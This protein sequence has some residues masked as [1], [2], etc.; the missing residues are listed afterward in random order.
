MQPA[1]RLEV[2]G[3]RVAHLLHSF[4]IQTLII[5]KVLALKLKFNIMVLVF[6]PWWPGL[7]LGLWLLYYCCQLFNNS[8][9]DRSRAPGIG[10]ASTEALL[11]RTYIRKL[12]SKFEFRFW[13]SFRQKLGPGP[14]P[15][16]PA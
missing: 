1:S 3:E 9:M 10:F 13:A 8:R 12:K 5:I 4:W 16:A 6:K 11:S 15:T 14:L 7:A 2:I